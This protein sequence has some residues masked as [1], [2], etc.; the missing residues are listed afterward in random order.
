MFSFTVYLEFCEFIST[1][2][3][4]KFLPGAGEDFW[5]MLTQKI[6][7]LFL[8]H[9]LAESKGIL[10]WIASHLYE[11]VIFM[12]IHIYDFL[13][14][15][16]PSFFALSLVVDLDSL[17]ASTIGLSE[18]PDTMVNNQVSQAFQ[19]IVCIC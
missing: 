14:F 19:F 9:N 2:H 5:H 11:I 4:V 1:V 10:W 3:I 17:M 15:S 7:S 8:L 6:T 12:F 18:M 16:G 13:T